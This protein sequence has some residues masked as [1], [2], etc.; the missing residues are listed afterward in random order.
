MSMPK[1]FKS[2]NGY[3]TS[4]SLCGKTYHEISDIMKDKGFKTDCL[5]EFPGH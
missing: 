2:Q 5:V 4:K 1:G 3:A